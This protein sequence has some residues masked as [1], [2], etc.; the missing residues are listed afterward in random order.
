MAS[1]P[2]LFEPESGTTSQG[3]EVQVRIGKDTSR[4]ILHGDF[5]PLATAR[6]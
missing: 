2:G 3:M 4:R 5:E 6:G 1:I